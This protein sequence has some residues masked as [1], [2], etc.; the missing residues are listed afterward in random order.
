[1]VNSKIQ[2]NPN[3]NLETVLDVTKSKWKSN[4]VQPVCSVLDLYV[5][6]PVLQ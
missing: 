6:M 2:P 3:Q 1:M 5:Y 4:T